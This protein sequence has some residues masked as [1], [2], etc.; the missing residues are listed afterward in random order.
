MAATLT[1]KDKIEPRLLSLL[2]AKGV[3]EAV[4]NRMGDAGLVNLD[5]FACIGTDKAAFLHAMSQDP[6]KVT[7]TDFAG[8]LEQA[9]M[10]PLGNQLGP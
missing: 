2:N 9:K 10:L 7:A 3:A 1:G 5:V 6:I 4:L 8:T